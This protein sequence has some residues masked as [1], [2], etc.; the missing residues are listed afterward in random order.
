VATVALGIAYPLA[1]TGAAQV[2]MPA[3]AD[4]SLVAVGDDGVG[5][6]LIGQSFTD[7]DGNPLPEYFQGRQSAVGYDASV[8]GGSNYGPEHPDLI[9]SIGANRTAIAEFNG[10]AEEDVPA[11]AVTA[12]ASGLDP[13]IS[14]EYARIQVERVA[15]TRGLEATDVQRLVDENTEGRML[16]FLGEPTVNVLAL[17]I[18]LDALSG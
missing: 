14:P 18:A 8:S 3:Q 7:A 11:D 17:N 9:A 1:V 12:S 5:S 6:A 2:A 10:V 15:A 4:G 16:G 13:D